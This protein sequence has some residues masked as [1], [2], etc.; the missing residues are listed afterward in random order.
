MTYLELS[1]YPRTTC[2]YPCLMISFQPLCRYR[3]VPR[4]LDVRRNILK[5]RKRARECLTDQAERMVFELQAG[6]I[7][8]DIVALPVP[9]VDRGRGTLATSRSHHRQERKRPLHHCHTTWH[10]V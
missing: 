3:S 2:H 7:I 8:G 1:V 6:N 5:D 10:P 9:T 4:H